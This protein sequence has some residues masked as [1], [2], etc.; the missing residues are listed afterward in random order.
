VGYGS[1][2]GFASVSVPIINH[3]NG[4]QSKPDYRVLAG[5]AAAF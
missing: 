4:L 2:S 3:M 1:V 5:I